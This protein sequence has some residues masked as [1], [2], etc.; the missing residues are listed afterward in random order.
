MGRELANYGKA[1][2]P[3][4]RDTLASSVPSRVSIAC[5]LRPLSV[6]AWTGDWLAV[7]KGRA[8]R[9]NSS[10]GAGAAG[11]RA[12]PTLQ[13]LPPPSAMAGKE[14]SQIR[15]RRALTAS[16]GRASGVLVP[17]GSRATIQV[18][19]SGSEAAPRLW[20]VAARERGGGVGAAPSTP[21]SPRRRERG[22]S[23]PL[24]P[25]PG[26]GA[27]GILKQT[28]AAPTIVPVLPPRS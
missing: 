15:A 17:R 20:T 24:S 22:L 1:P 13:R 28:S 5:T 6:C 8:R 4:A 7:G 27:R 11:G 12:K 3:P 9:G 18:A 25:P 10:G 2:L 23:P 19:E 16:G 26:I 14:R 21:V